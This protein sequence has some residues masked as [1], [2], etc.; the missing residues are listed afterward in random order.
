MPADELGVWRQPWNKLKQPYR[1]KYWESFPKSEPKEDFD[2]RNALYATRVNVLDSILYK[3]EDS[4][5][6]M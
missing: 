5:R 2:H 6:Q 1:K 3:G 4:Y